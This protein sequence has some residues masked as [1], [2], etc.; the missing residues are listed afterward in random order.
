MGDVPQ[1]LPCKN[2]SKEYVD[3]KTDVSRFKSGYTT[4]IVKSHFNG[5]QKISDLFFDMLMKEQE[6]IPANL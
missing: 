5:P 1:R 3:D 4:F 2:I 6:E